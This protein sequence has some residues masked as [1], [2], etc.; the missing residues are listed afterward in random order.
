MELTR[1]IINI[2]T[3]TM[4]NS[5]LILVMGIMIYS[6]ESV[7]STLKTE[8]NNPIVLSGNEF[9]LTTDRVAMHPEVMFPSDTLKESDY[10]AMETKINYNVVFSDD[11]LT[12]SI[13]D[14]IVGSRVSHSAEIS[15]YQ[16]TEGLFA[17]GRLVVWKEDNTWEAEYTWYGSGVPVIKSE[18]GELRSKEQ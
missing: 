12:V 6:C 14:T 10:V 11:G 17:G 8:D 5:I 15:K 9:I 13:N 1:L 7:P 18:R 16:L 4:K 3:T 2:K